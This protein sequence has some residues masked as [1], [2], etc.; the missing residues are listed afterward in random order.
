MFL[1][2]SPYIGGKIMNMFVRFLVYLLLAIIG[3]LISSIVTFNNPWLGSLLFAG[4]ELLFIGS[5][6]M[7]RRK[8]ERR[9]LG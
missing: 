8:N 3:V 2:V 7:W 1:Y 5:F 4:I 9:T 6:V